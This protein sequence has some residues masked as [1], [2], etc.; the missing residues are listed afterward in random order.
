MSSVKQTMRCKAFLISTLLISLLTLNANA[1][2]VVVNDG[3]IS[4]K[5]TDKIESMGA[6]LYAK[7]G[8]SVHVALPASL[9]GKSIVLYKESLADDLKAPFVLLTIAKN[10][11]Q[12][13]IIN[14]KSLDEKF[15]REGVLSPY[16]WS[17]TILPLLTLRKA[18]D[19]YNAATLNGY[20]D[21]V[22]QIA[23]SHNIKL[24][25]AIGSTN[26]NIYL[27]LKIVIYGFLFFILS[28]YIFRRLTAK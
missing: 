24:K 22:E 21:I 14:S 7:T 18:T 23:K 28:R 20:A 5:V 11:K 26:K 16:P 4:Q 27:Y 25:E 13:D 15:D 12:I 6:E 8:I 10:E 1:S 3:V 2:F 17:G 19:K 9:D